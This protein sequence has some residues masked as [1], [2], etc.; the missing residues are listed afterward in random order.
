[1]EQEQGPIA[2]QGGDPDLQYSGHLQNRRMDR[3]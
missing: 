1:M 2:A 3:L